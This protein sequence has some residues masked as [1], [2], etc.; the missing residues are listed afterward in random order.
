MSTPALMERADTRMRCLWLWAS[1]D[2]EDLGATL[3][4]TLHHGASGLGTQRVREGGG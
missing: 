3:G 2:I 4:R 1:S